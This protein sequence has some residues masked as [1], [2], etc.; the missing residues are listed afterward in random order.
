MSKRTVI[1]LFVTFLSFAAIGM[2]IDLSKFF[3]EA[4]SL[5]PIILLILIISTI[6]RL[7]ICS[8]RCM[9]T[10][11]D[12]AELDLRLSMEG[13]LVSS[14]ASLFLPTA[15]GGDAVRIEYLSQKGNLSRPKSAALVLVERV[16]GLRG[17]FC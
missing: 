7:I 9:R 10:S 4:L 11:P 1:Q 2:V 5:N 17:C 6:L 16:C 13:Y 15:I 14:Y 12:I 3:S 8:I